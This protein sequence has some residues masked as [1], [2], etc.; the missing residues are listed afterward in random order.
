MMRWFYLKILKPVAVYLV[1]LPLI[2]SRIYVSSISTLHPFFRNVLLDKTDPVDD[3][4]T[5]VSHKSNNGQEIKLKFYIPNPMCAMRADRFSTKEPETLKWIEEYGTN[6]SVLFDIGANIGQYS[7]YHSLLN[8]GNSVAFEPSLFNVKQLA[9]N[10]NANKMEDKVII[11]T[12]PLSINCGILPFKASTTREG[13]AGNAFGVNYGQ[14]G[15]DIKTII[16]S[17]IL[18]FSLDTLIEMKFINKPNLIKLDVDGIEHLILEGAKNTL[19]FDGL[20]TVLVEVNDNFH[21]QADTVE[22]I[23]YNC[24]FNLKGKYYLGEPS[25]PNSKVPNYNQIWVKNY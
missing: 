9:K 10:I 23:L 22:K 14:N 25:S 19:L 7:I 1:E 24:G 2:I 3:L 13:D 12:N 17:Q 18:G 11:I 4:M 21:Q 6:G 5:V 15:T 8:N 16:S 20:K